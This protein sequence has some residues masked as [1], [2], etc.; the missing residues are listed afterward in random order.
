MSKQYKNEDL[1]DTFGLSHETIRRYTLDF[2]E[3]LSEG[4][5]PPE[6]KHRSYDESDLRVFAV[7]ASMKTANHSNDDIKQIL[8]AGL[9]GRL[10]DTVTIESPTLS[11]TIE[12]TIARQEI[13][14]LQHAIEQ[15]RKEKEAAQAEAQEWRDKA[16]KADGKIEELKEQVD[17]LRTQL[18]ATQSKQDV[19]A[20]HKEI[21]RLTVLLEIA[22]GK[23]E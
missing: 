9:E 22:K 12:R 4:A 23:G 5:N 14:K 2:A 13:G 20:L 6:G 19:I 21:A 1:R 8:R 16:N 11:P 18:E 15:E 7:I 3:F 17:S 10:A